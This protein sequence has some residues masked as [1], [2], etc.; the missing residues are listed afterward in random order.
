[1][2]VHMQRVELDPS[3]TPYTETNQRRTQDLSVRAKIINLLEENTA[4]KLHD[5]GFRNYLLDMTPK[6]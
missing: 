4:E 2:D 1:M 5:N 6:A 3:H